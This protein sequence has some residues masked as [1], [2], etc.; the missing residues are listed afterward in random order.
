MGVNALI[1][2]D[3]VSFG[4]IVIK[5]KKYRMRDV[6]I[7]PDGTVQRR[8]FSRWLSSHHKYGK[9]D[10][11]D[12]VAVGAETVVIGTG[13]YSGVKLTEDMREYANESK[14]E[15][16]DLPSRDAIQKFN[17]QKNLGK[18]VGALIHMLC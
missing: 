6:V 11:V 17:E 3:S 7:L 16:V 2:I 8:K 12:L 10:I 4:V 15:L 5:G 9:E 14:C 1:K 18:R 13:I